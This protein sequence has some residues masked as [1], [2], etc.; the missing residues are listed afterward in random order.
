VLLTSCFMSRASC[1][2]RPRCRE[3]WSSGLCWK[4]LDFDRLRGCCGLL[5]VRAGETEGVVV[6]SGEETRLRC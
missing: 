3:I 1:L 5:L 2:R 4:D 6:D